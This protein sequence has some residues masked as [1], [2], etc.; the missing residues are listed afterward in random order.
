MT[1]CLT[2]QRHLKFHALLPEKLKSATDSDL[3]LSLISLKNTQSALAVHVMKIEGELSNRGVSKYIIHQDRDTESS[4]KNL[5]AD[6]ADEIILF[7]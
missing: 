7:T 2:Q 6:A 3:R 1:D 5:D 4:K